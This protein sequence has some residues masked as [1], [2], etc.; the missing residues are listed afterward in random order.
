MPVILTHP[1]IFYL[2]FG[3]VDG[4]S[5]ELEERIPAGVEEF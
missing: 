1:K 5:N 4:L 2:V 3:L